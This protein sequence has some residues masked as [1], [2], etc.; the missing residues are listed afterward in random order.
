[1]KTNVNFKK[2]SKR[3]RGRRRL[4]AGL[5]LAAALVAAVLLLHSSHPVVRRERRAS[6]HRVAATGWNDSDRRKLQREIAMLMKPSLRGASAWS[7]TVLAA[8]GMRLYGDRAEAAVTPASAQKVIVAATALHVLG[9]QFRFPTLLAAVSQPQGGN[10]A[11]DLWLIGAGDPSLVSND[12]RGGLKRLMQQGLRQ[13]DGGIVV[14]ASAFRGPEYNPFWS[15][16]DANEDYAAP[17]SGISLDQDTAEFEITG[18]NAGERAQIQ[19]EPRSNAISYSGAIKTT[20]SSQDS[21]VIIGAAQTGNQFILSGH[22]PA[23]DREVY[24]LPIR[25]VPTYV[26]SVLA[27]MLRDRG[28]HTGRPARLGNAPL[29]LG[30]L[31]EHHSQPL[32]ELIGKM[33]FESNNHFAEQVL[34]TIGA[35]QGAAGS[36]ANGL[37]AERTYL[38]A[39]DVATPGLHLVDGSGLS[40]DDRIASITLARL[41]ARENRLPGGNPIY[42]LLPRGGLDGT[43]RNYRF[44]SALG[45][46]RAK[47]GHITGVESLAGYVNT[48]RH[49]RLIFAFMVNGS[50]GDPDDAIV[51]SVD[52]LADF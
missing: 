43:L 18:T 40:D 24:Y 10:L 42:Q 39:L 28:I 33:L 51:A 47:S 30:V 4:S 9:A 6:V 8:D 1:M 50:P 32:H 5:V 48:R 20:G 14:D 11:G 23:G 35:S 12:L 2:K 15:L 31:W 45:R 38:R 46:V 44:G 3:S 25:G 13:I 26:G 22:L 52:R 29:G 36:D 34:R 16:D 37:L 21:T 41:L 7:C 49:G 27:Q 19:L 17:T